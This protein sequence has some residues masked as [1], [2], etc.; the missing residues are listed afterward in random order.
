MIQAKVRKVGNSLGLILPREVLRVLGVAEGDS[1]FLI[2]GP[3]GYRLSPYDPEFGRQM[4]AA[5]EGMK[6]YR[7]ALRELSER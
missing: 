2:E 5:E 1:L 6:A 4:E 7:N 3:D